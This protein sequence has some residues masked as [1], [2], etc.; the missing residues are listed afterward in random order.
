MSIRPFRA[1]L[2]L[3][4]C[5]ATAACLTPPTAPSLPSGSTR[6][7]FLG[8]SLTYTNDL[9]GMLLRLARLAGDTSVS[10][11]ALAEPDYSLEEHWK[12]GTAP[13]WLRE[14]QW[15]YVVMQQ[16]SSALP[17]S[18]VHLR[19]WT[20]QFA[21]L[22]RAA[23]AQPVLLM[24]WPQQGRLFDFPNVLTSYRNAAGSVGGLFAPA[25][26]AW[27]AY[28]QYDR[29]YSDGLH[30]TGPGTYLTALT[31]LARL[32]DIRP[33]QLPPTIPGMPM[34]SADVRALQRAATAALDRN[35]A[36][37]PVAGAMP[38]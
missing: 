3:L 15:E 24:V 14:R 35:P 6:V 8:N 10:V 33:E 21:P 36:R 7:L 27:T 11:A 17:A 16:G 4:A 25:G 30:P 13:R 5:V 20:E 2:L 19:S 32:R 22:I 9:P 1:V 37:P 18:Q 26:D 31:L 28:G 12:Q 29:L 38:Q 34:D 23:G